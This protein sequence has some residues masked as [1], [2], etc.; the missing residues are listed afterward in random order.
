MNGIANINKPTGLS[1]S[2]VVIKARNAVSKAIGEKI[3]A[4]HLGTLDPG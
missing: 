2:D 4:G 1:S 3:K